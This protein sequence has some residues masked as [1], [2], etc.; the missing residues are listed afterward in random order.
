MAR[1]LATSASLMD[2]KSLPEVDCSLNRC[3]ANVATMTE[4]ARPETAP[5]RSALGTSGS[6]RPLRKITTK[7]AMTATIDPTT[8]PSQRAS[9]MP[10][11]ATIT[12]CSYR[13]RVQG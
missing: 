4:A 5:E 7:D 3:R 12:G 10:K 9:L 2:V 11:S 8:N 6:S 13:S 1:T